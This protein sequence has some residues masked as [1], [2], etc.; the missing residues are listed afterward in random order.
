DSG[1]AKTGLPPSAAPRFIE[2]TRRERTSRR[3]RHSLQ[4]DAADGDLLP[5][6]VISDVVT[7]EAHYAVGGGTVGADVGD[8]TGDAG[9]ALE[10]RERVA[11]GRGVG[12]TRG[13]ETGQDDLVRVG[14]GEREAGEAGVRML[15]REQLTELGGA[16]GR[17]AGEHF[18]LTEAG[19]DEAVEGL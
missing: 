16:C 18:R 15:G 6:S 8:L 1:A 5:G 7:V 9:V 10:L 13:L 11:Q 2:A 19:E 17:L 4:L 3:C 12:L 14:A